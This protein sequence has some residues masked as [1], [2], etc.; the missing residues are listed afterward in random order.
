MT[1]QGYRLNPVAWL[2]MKAK[3]VVNSY[4]AKRRAEKDAELRLKKIQDA[5][6]RSIIHSRM[7]QYKKENNIVE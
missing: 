3:A 6:L 1:I 4:R 7:E 5:Y 2:F